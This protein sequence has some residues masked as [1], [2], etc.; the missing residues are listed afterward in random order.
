M[1]TDQGQNTTDKPLIHADVVGLSYGGGPE[2]L[3]QV[4]FDVRRGEFVSLL[5][6]SGCGKSSL[7]RIMA[8]LQTATAGQLTVAGLTPGNSRTNTLRSA[9]VFQ[10]PT[11]LP[12]RS[13]ER[14]VALPFE[15][16][17]TPSAEYLPQVREVLELV[18]LHESDAQKRPRMLSGGMRMRASLARALVTRPDLM[19][20]DEPFAALD[21][22]LRHQLNEEILRIWNEQ[23]WTAVFVTHNIA[24]AVFLSSRILVMSPRPGRIV[25]DIRVPFD[26]PRSIE[27]RAEPG[28]ARLLGEVSRELRRS[29]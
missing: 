17:G 7:L 3:H 25:A 11:L 23:R 6:P 28:F 19:L 16:R 8:G 12:W 26:Y 18:G 15:L 20:M 22:I 5:G 13:V 14:N 29:A 21:D 1:T 10:E 9:F 27:L 4:S 24:E 2:V